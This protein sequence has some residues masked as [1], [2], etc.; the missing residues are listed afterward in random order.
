MRDAVA[1][2]VDKARKPAEVQ[3]ARRAMPD[4]AMVH[5]LA[6]TFRALSDPTRVRIVLA[7]GEREL[8]V[9]DLAHLLGLTGSAV[10]HQL[11]LL[12][13]QGLVRYR[14]DGKAAFYALDDEHLRNLLAEGVRHV[15]GG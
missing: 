14:R 7:L 11:R 12:R 10:S 3:A 4:D 9:G 5:A 6:E 8:C 15:R 1:G 13:G 2:A